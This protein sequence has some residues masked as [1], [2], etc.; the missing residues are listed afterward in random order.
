MLLLIIILLK[1]D[2]IT[3]NI[4]ILFYAKHNNYVLRRKGNQFY[5]YLRYSIFA[6]DAHVNIQFNV[7]IDVHILSWQLIRIFF[8]FL[9]KC[10]R[11]NKNIYQKSNNL[12]NITPIIFIVKIL[13]FRHLCTKNRWGKITNFVVYLWRNGLSI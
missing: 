1:S 11:K 6:F 10:A 12:R 3:Y 4:N 9:F 2:K 5:K 13:N 7:R 8:L